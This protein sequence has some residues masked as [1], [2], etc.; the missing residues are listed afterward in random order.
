MRVIGFDPSKTCTGVAVFDGG[1]WETWSLRCPI[2]RPKGATAFNA[3]YTG[4]V[5]NW[6]GA[7]V[8]V[9]VGSSGL[10]A[11]A[12]EQ[13]L[14]TSASGKSGQM[15]IQTVHL[16]HGIAAE[17]CAICH[18]HDVPAVYVDQGKWR[19]AFGVSGAGRAAKKRS[20]VDVC[21]LEG[22]PVDSD[23]AAE[24]VGI[25]RWLYFERIGARFSRT[26]DTPLFKG[27]T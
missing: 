25:A 4:E 21:R 17:I 1:T 24:A 5:I 10:D 16:L 23:D 13:P 7:K 2:K 15:P 9:L 8:E 19:R 3:D 22:I 14:V 20:A 27:T 11:A 12:I 6:I 26:A 18:A